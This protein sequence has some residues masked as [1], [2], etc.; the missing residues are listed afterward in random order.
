MGS[1]SVQQFLAH[2]DRLLEDAQ[3]G[4][5]ALVTQDGEPVLLALPLGRASQS[6]TVKLELAVALFDRAQLSLG[7]AAQIAGFSYGEMVDELARRGIPVI[8]LAPGELDRELAA[9]GD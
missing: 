7:L 3:H 1:I 8:R 2:P 6:P 4:S 5:I 9:L